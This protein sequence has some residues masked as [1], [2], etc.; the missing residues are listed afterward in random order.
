MVIHLT[1][2]EKDH[3]FCGQPI[4]NKG[5]AS[6][7]LYK[8]NVCTDCTVPV[9]INSSVKMDDVLFGQN[10]TRKRTKTHFENEKT[11]EEGGL[12][13]SV[14][15]AASFWRTSGSKLRTYLRRLQ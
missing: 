10:L 8:Y 14:R 7:D 2:L 11:C 15:H 3:I 1:D 4:E 13:G 6:D 9:K 5:A 12:N